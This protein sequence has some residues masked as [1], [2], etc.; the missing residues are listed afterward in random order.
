M[1][2]LKD[3]LQHEEYEQAEVRLHKWL[4]LTQIRAAADELHGCRWSALTR[5]TFCL[6]LWSSARR[7]RRPSACWW[8]GWIWTS[9]NSPLARC[10]CSCLPLQ[11]RLQL[12]GPETVNATQVLAL[13]EAL[14]QRVLTVH[15]LEAACAV[16]GK[17]A[18]FT[19]RTVNC[20]SQVLV[21][22]KD[23]YQPVCAAHHTC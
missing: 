5:R 22:S 2:R 18:Q 16:C 14:Q 6:I 9:E 8:L 12:L 3:L 20:Q 15:H 11:S 7:Q 17:A 1:A 19:Q 4:N 23:I 21:G 10:G 13:Q